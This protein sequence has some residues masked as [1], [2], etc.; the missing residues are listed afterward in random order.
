LLLTT[1]AAIGLLFLL[2][3]FA[4]VTAGGRRTLRRL[5][6]LFALLVVIV[7]ALPYA[8]WLI[9]AGV[10]AV[11]ALPQLGD[12][13]AR[14]V[15]MAWLLGGLVLGAA[16]I[17]MLAFLNSGWFAAKGEEA[18]IIYR[19]PV[20]PLARQFVYFFALAPALCAVLLSGLFGFDRVIGGPGVLLVMSGLA[21]V[22]AAGDLIAMRHQRV[23]R[24]V[25]AAAIVAPAAGVVLGILLLPWTGSGEIATSMPARAISDFFDDSFVRRTNQRLRAVAGDTEIASLIALHSGRPHLWIDAEPERTPWVTPARFS[26]TGGVVVWRASDTAGTPPPDIARR[27]P[28]IVP[29]VPRAFEWLVT[30]RQPLLRI[31]WAIVRPKGS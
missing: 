23:L 24:M 7:L 5:D 27:F 14:A 2:A 9:R 8:I 20:E 3:V 29:E 28:G 16:T 11:P 25:W 1:P 19:P 18:P 15:N 12:L 21:V 6:P 26:E 4:L 31:G 22:V 17:P 30:G 10:L 13:N